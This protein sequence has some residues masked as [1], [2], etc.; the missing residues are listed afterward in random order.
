[1]T[2]QLTQPNRPET[3]RNSWPRSSGLSPARRGQENRQEEGDTT[4]AKDGGGDVDP[5]DKRRHPESPAEKHSVRNTRRSLRR[6]GGPIDL[7]R[8]CEVLLCDPAFAVR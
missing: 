2:D 4:N 6:G 8:E 5:L 3:A 7:T 1:M